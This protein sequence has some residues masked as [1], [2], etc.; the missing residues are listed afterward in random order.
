MVGV[1]FVPVPDAGQIH[2]HALT[3]VKTAATRM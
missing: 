2:T 3:P 1:V